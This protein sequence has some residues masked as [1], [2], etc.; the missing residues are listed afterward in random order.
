MIIENRQWNDL[1]IRR[2]ISSC[3]QNRNQ[4]TGK[5]NV[6]NAYNQYRHFW[7]DQGISRGGFKN[8]VN[9]VKRAQ[10]NTLPAS[11][12]DR[13]HDWYKRLV[14]LIRVSFPN[15]KVNDGAFIRIDQAFEKKN[16]MVVKVSSPLDKVDSNGE[17]V[18]EVNEET[19]ASRKVALRDY[20]INLGFT[21][22]PGGR[23]TY[24]GGPFEIGFA[25]G[26]FASMFGEDA[27]RVFTQLAD[28]PFKT[29]QLYGAQVLGDCTFS[30]K[31]W[32]SKVRMCKEANEFMLNM[33]ETRGW[34]A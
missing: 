15:M 3:L 25:T 34:A 6:W 13:R 30:N 26:K 23:F 2:L 8:M 19:S 29:I 21:M 7:R 31:D 11:E 28:T 12:Y 16:G 5:V 24:K 10:G 18:L 4:K 27:I 33:S 32:L 20:L 9:R 22:H 1:T 14:R 17:I